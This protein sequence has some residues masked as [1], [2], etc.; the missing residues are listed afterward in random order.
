MH[1]LFSRPTQFGGRPSKVLPPGGRIPL[2]PCLLVSPFSTPGG[3]PYVWKNPVRM[4]K[5]Q[6]GRYGYPRR[7]RGT[8]RI[9]HEG[10]WRCH[11]RGRCWP[12]PWGFSKY[13][14]PFY[15]KEETNVSFLRKG[16][17]LPDAAQA[18]TPTN[19]EFSYC[20]D[21]PFCG[22]DNKDTSPPAYLR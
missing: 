4:A 7:H 8:L 9:V 15:P 13:A 1:R 19:R 16:G 11:L 5:G 17:I 22:D 10:I 2:C 3:R 18:E 6:L 21:C 12:I 14:V 20:L